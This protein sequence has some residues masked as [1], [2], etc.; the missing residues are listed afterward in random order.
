MPIGEDALAG[1]SFSVEIDGVT[2]AQFKEVSG[3][4]AEIQTIEHRENTL[5][6]LPVLKKLPGAQKW[7]DLTLKRGKHRQHRPLGLDQAGAGRATSTAPAR[8]ARSCSTTTSTARSRGSTSRTAGRRRSASARCRREATTSSSRSA[9]SP[10][11][12]SR[13]HDGRAERGRGRAARRAGDALQTEF[14]FELPRGFVD[15]VGPG[16][17][18][19][20]HAAGDGAGRDH[21]AARP[22]GARQRGYLTVLLLSRVDHARSGRSRRSRPP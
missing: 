15:D 1:Y 5:K 12:G 7:G 20:R 13:P 8:T 6:G 16:A 9:P 21:A 14:R 3:L 10:T 18:R 11:K 4:S 2:I 19:G 17:P 22:A